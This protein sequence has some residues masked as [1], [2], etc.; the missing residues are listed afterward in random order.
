MAFEV[1]VRLPGTK[2]WCGIST[3]AIEKYF[4]T[5]VSL[6]G[7]G[8]LF[9]TSVEQRENFCVFDFREIKHKYVCVNRCALC[10]SQ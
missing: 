1:Y 7:G 4:S 2:C 6:V 5:S 9:L 10:S 8:I 3:I